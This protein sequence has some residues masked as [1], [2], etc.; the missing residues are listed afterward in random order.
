MKISKT[1]GYNTLN[2]HE[3]TGGNTYTEHDFTTHVAMNEPIG[4]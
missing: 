2:S 4:M 3:E 1:K